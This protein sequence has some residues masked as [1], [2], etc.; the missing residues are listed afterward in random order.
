MSSLATGESDLL[1]AILEAAVRNN[2][3]MNVTG[4]LLYAD[5]NVM[6]VLE[7]EKAVVLEL[8]QTIKLDK[9]HSGIFVLVEQEIAA[10]QF[11]S[12]S[13]GFKHI[14]EADLA[15]F[16]AAAQIFKARQDEILLRSR[17]G[18]ALTILK[19]FADGVIG[20]S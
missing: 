16:P 9:R 20:L 2:K 19:T 5:G 1:P 13:M 12:W 6:Q 14:K 11:A 4:M 3:Q 7:G 15:K 17:A 18:N 10:R 8:F